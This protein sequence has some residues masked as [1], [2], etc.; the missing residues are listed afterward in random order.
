MNA[1]IITGK[2]TSEVNQMILK[3]GTPVCRFTLSRDSR[4][5]D[6]LLTGQ[7]VVSFVKEIEKG[8]ELTIDCLINDHLQLLVQ[9]YRIESRPL[10]LGQVWDYRG[11]PLANNKLAF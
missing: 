8:T 10:R 1:A 7:K 6:C 11:R 9:A 2:V 3:S 5:F 4:T